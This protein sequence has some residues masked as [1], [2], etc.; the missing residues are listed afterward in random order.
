MKK[1][2]IAA[3]AAS[4]FSSFAAIGVLYWT[5]WQN[6]P[7]A[8]VPA[9]SWDQQNLKRHDSGCP[10]AIF[11]APR[12]ELV[13]CE[14]VSAEMPA[15]VKDTVKVF[16]T[17]TSAALYVVGK[18]YAQNR[19]YEYGGVILKSGAGYIFSSPVTQRHGTNVEFNEDPEAYDFPIV[20]IYHVHPCLKGVVPSVFSP[21]DLA[22]ARTA[23]TPAYVLD[24][25][26]GLLHYW[27]PG[28]GYL[29]ADGMLKIGVSP[30]ALMQGIQLSPGKIVGG[31]KV[32]GALLN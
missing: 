2:F 32:D 21:Q 5:L 15:P 30:I 24:E 7:A 13:Q 23:K 18:I 26:T 6:L 4:L 8:P 25:C 19:Y 1:F 14:M 11:V 17:V 28:D 3:L 29:D 12:G 10:T 27:A 9:Q 31:I 20:A 16:P 22:G